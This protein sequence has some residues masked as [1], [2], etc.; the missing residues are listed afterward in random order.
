MEGILRRY[1]QGMA[2]DLP[3]AQPSPQRG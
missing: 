2:D 3:G 1:R